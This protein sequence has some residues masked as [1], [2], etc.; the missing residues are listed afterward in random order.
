VLFR[1]ISD[2]LSNVLEAGYINVGAGGFGTSAVSGGSADSG[3][4]F[5]TSGNMCFYTNKCYTVGINTLVRGSIG[6]VGQAGTGKLCSGTQYSQ[7]G[8]W[9]GGSGL[10][11]DGQI[12][13][14]NSNASYGRGILGATAGAGAGYISCQTQYYCIH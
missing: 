4:A 5:D 9:Y 11:G 8:Y 3:M 14:G 1:S 6:L 12:L 10:G 13:A 2:Y 7:G